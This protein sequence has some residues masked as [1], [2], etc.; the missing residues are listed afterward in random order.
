MASLHK[1]P[2][3]RSPY[4]YCAFSLPNGKR[5]FKSTKQTN[6][7]EAWHVCMQWEKASEAA[8]KG[9]LTEVQAR[10]VLN[11]ILEST[12]EGPMRTNSVR[13]FFTNWL[14]GK[15]LATKEDTFLHYRKEVSAFFEVLGSR[16]DKW[17]GTLTPADI[18]NFRD[19]RIKQGLSQATVAQYVKA[20]R[21]VLNTARRQGL[22]LHN[23]A[24]AVDLPRRVVSHE[25]DVFMPDEVRALLD[26]A[27]PDWKTAILL[28]HY[29]GS[30]LTDT[31]SLTWANVDLVES[32]IFYTQGKTGKRVEVP[33]HP[34]LEEHLLSIAGDNPR[35]FLS[36]ALAKLRTGGH[37]GLSK[38]FAAIMAKAGIDQR[39][40]QTSRNHKFSRLS[41]HSLRHGFSSTLANAGISADV[42]MKLIGHKSLDVHQR[43]THMQ[44][45]PLKQAIAALP[46][47]NRREG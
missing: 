8:G 21:S 47:L 23:P 4:F 37:R 38:Q 36:P 10:R 18:E 5:R 17:L 9:S 45:E 40:V 29:I 33:I 11:E 31:V 34:A 19:A 6:R 39:R 16:A 7:K 2:H 24:E 1:D 43:Y 30:R 32:V 28:G 41:F 44:L 22:I 46:T 15:K 3:G 42:R 27:S 25:R 12:G 20:I 26:V 13:E 14:A 35:G